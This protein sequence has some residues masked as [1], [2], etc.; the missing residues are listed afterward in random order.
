M[1]DYNKEEAKKD[2]GLLTLEVSFIPAK[3]AE[4]LHTKLSDALVL[5]IDDHQENMNQYA[6]ENYVTR[7]V[8]LMDDMVGMEAKRYM[9]L[10][11]ENDKDLEFLKQM[12]SLLELYKDKRD[13][14]KLEYVEKM[15]NDWIDELEP[16]DAII[17]T[18]E[19][20]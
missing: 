3:I 10:K 1:S 17:A 4:M 15:I 12:R 19:P 8:A 11:S 6:L 9:K 13:F 20:S 5:A 16:K 2:E 7:V 18:V 14:T